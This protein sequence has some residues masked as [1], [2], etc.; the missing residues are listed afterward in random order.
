MP[1]L[2]VPLPGGLS[3]PVRDLGDP[4]GPETVLLLHGFPQDSTCWRLVTPHLEQHRLLLP[5]QRGAAADARPPGVE[6]YR[7]PVLVA[8]A[9]AVLDAAG[10]ERAHVVGHDWGAA[11]AWHLAARHPHRVA[12]LVAVSV[13]HPLAFVVA[14]R[15]DD[16]ARTRSAYMKDFAREGYDEV[17]LADGADGLRRLFADAGPQVDV[18][19]MVALVSEPGALRALLGWYA[20]ARAEDVLDTPDVTVPTVHVWSDGDAFLAGTGARGTGRHVTGPYRLEVLRGVSHWV[21]EE[22]PDVLGPLVAAHVAAHPT[23]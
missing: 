4:G 1:R 23:A 22:A 13:P 18:E 14:L 6:P 16:D 17:L 20:A 19:R 7:M 10:V 5:D 9:L 2:R 8:D 15:S 3:L 12:S 21:P 11:V